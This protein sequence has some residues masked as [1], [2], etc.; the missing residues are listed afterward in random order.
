MAEA[1]L[2]AEIEGL[3]EQRRE[4]LREGDFVAADETDS[5]IDELKDKM[6]NAK[7]PQVNPNTLTTPPEYHVFVQ[8]N[9]WYN[10]DPAYHYAAD[11][12]GYEFMKVNPSARP[13]DLYH[14]VETKMREKFPELGGKRKL[15]PPSPDGGGQVPREGSGGRGGLTGVK[16]QMSEMERGIMKNLVQSGLF[17]N[18][19]EYL[20]QY[21]DAP[22]RN[23]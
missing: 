7:A 9:P 5:K 2:K 17:K 12:I 22:G 20:K 4:A 6:A 19:E 21:V 8:R 18:E 13:A 11:G 10:E 16:A 15:S 1:Q 14:F 23:R 3:K